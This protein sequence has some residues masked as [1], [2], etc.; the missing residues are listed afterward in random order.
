METLVIFDIE[1]TGLPKRF[2]APVT[3]V[4]NWPRI[5]QLSYEVCWSNGETIKKKTCLIKPDGW[6]VPS[7]DYFIRKGV[8]PHLAPNMAK[9]WTDNGFM[10]EQNIAEGEPIEQVLVEMLQSMNSAD[11][12]ISHNLAFDKPVLACEMYRYGVSPGK[13]RKSHPYGLKPAGHLRDYCT[14][15]NSTDVCCIPGMYGKH[16]WPSLKEAYKHLTGK[17]F[18]D[19]HDAGHDV[20]A[21]KE[22]YLMLVALDDI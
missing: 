9:F 15:V 4:D 16:K 3:D 21:C 18:T 6:E 19:G 22:V 20:Q 10:Q 2:D 11:V 7:A 14:K 8:E 1:S 13:V 12:L 5:L 17:D